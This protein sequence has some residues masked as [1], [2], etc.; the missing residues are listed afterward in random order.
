[1]RSE[2]KTNQPTNQLQPQRI[3]LEFLLEGHLKHGSNL[4]RLACQ[5][6]EGVLWDNI[7]ALLRL[8]LRIRIRTNVLSVRHHRGVSFAKKSSN[9][10]LASATMN[11]FTL[12]I[13]HS[14]VMC[15]G[16]LSLC[17]AVY[18]F[19]NVL[20]PENDHSSVM[21]AR[22]LSLRPAIYVFINVLILERDRTSVKHVPHRSRNCPIYANMNVFIQHKDLLRARHV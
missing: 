20:I 2:I 14:S 22:S 3:I 7:L 1:M 17:Q 12:E 19:I 21:H 9:T 10:F 6:H 8:W 16:G 5:L 13:D 4:M 15:A 11:V 18:V